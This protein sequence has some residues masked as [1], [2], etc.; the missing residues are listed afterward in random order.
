MKNRTL[1]PT[2]VLFLVAAVSLGAVS[3]PR[4]TANLL[5][6]S[7]GNPEKSGLASKPLPDET[8]QKT[9]ATWIE[10]AQNRKVEGP[11]NR[12]SLV[13]VSRSVT[14]HLLPA[15]LVSRWVNAGTQ[16]ESQLLILF[17][18]GLIGISH[19]LRRGSWSRSV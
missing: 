2:I 6:P 8:S 4:V 9:L 15:S 19:L 17:G 3:L 5:N 10:V 7:G 11:T 16:G 18:F 12:K 13:P 1:R 14:Q